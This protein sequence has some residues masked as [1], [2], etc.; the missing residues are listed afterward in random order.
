MRFVCL[1]GLHR[2][3]P[4]TSD[5]V[6]TFRTCSRCGKFREPRDPGNLDWRFEKWR[7]PGSGD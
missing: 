6:G 5:G 3:G 2:W 7:G 1:V 4:M